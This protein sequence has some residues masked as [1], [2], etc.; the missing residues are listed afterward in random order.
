MRVVSDLDPSV[1]YYRDR[2]GF[3]C[4]VFGDP[5]DFATA[6]RDEAAILLALY[7]E[8]TRIVPNWR[9]VDKIWNA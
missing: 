3:A 6:E 2:L 4:D 7:D 1:A 9:I 5:P 8:S